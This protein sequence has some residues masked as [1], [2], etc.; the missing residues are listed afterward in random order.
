MSQYEQ[1]K[2]DRRIKKAQKYRKEAQDFYAKSDEAICNIPMGQP[3][4]IGHHSEGRHRRALENS[5]RNLGKAVECDE[6]AKH[7][8]RLVKHGCFDISSDDENA[9]PKLQA[10]LC[11]LEQRQADMKQANREYKLGGWQK[12]SLLSDDKKQALKANP[13]KGPPFEGFQLTN[14]LATVRRIKLRIVKLQAEVLRVVSADV[15][16][17]GFKVS[18]HKEDNR[19]WVEFAEKPQRDVC[20]IMRTYAFKWSPARCAWVRM[21]NDAGRYAAERLVIQ[22]N[23]IYK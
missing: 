22:L 18:E 12:V 21:L 5:H 17:N 9:L 7:Y 16:G 14:N 15:E 10:K 23:T 19:V 8:E 13:I 11:K 2:Q 20:Q 3:I 6:K 4:L 1:A